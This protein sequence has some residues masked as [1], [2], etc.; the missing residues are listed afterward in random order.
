MYLQCNLIG[1]FAPRCISSLLLSDVTGQCDQ[2][3]VAVA[4][5]DQSRG[6]VARG[7]IRLES[8]G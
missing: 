7:E 2:E 3:M 6:G 5:G 1:C 8:G 4:V